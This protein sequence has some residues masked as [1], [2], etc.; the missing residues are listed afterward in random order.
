MKIALIATERLPIPPIRGGAVETYIFEAAKRLQKHHQITV[1][2]CQD[3]LLPNSCKDD[4]I[5]YIR[6]SGETWLDFQVAL[7]LEVQ[8]SKYDLIHIFNRPQLVSPLRRIAPNSK[9]VLNL[10]NDHL[11][12]GLSSQ[13]ASRCVEDV[14]YIVTNSNY[15]RKRVVSHF[16]LAYAKCRT[17]YL[18]VDTEQFYPYWLQGEKRAALR[19]QY[20]LTDKKV[21]L[22]AGRLTKDKGVHL[23]IQALGELRTTFPQLVLVIAGSS[24]YGGDSLTEYVAKLTEL[25]ANQKEAIIFTGFVPPQQMPEI[26]LLGDVF[27]CPST[28]PEPFGRVNIE[29]MAC[30]LPVVA[31]KR[32]GIPEVIQDSYSGFLVEDNIDLKAYVQ[33]ISALLTNQAMARAMGERGRILVENKFTWPRV[34][35]E[36]ME[37]YDQDCP[38]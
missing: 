20:G 23:I 17:V 6:L 13:E 11:V 30:G 2:S 33:L 10:H 31:S 7:W 26:F 19:S 38:R 29:A 32:G 16:P 3:P 8:Q 18:G 1:F 36:L 21:L 24:W 14:D 35:K 28:W 4:N 15:T 25:A 37:I 9:L 5:E 22:F 12:K 34:V 27:I